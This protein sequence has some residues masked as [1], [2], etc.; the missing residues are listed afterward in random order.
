MAQAKPGGFIARLAFVFAMAALV[1]AALPR[2]LAAQ[3]PSPFVVSGVTVDET[4]ATAAQARE[5]AMA[6][7][8]RRAFRQLMERLVPQEQSAQLPRP[9]AAQLNDLVENF[10]VEDER[11]SAVR[12]IATLTFRFSPDGVRALL[13]RAGLPFAETFARPM[14]MLPVFR[15]DD[16]PVLWDEPNPW[17]AAWRALPPE[18]GLQPLAIPLGD[19]SDIGNVSAEQAVRGE[20]ERIEAI[21]RRYGAAGAIV[22]E[23]SLDD[24]GDAPVV[25]VAV[26]RLDSAVPEQTVVESFAGRPGETREALLE[27]AASQVSQTIQERW[28]SEV[29]L[30][31]GPERTLVSEVA[32]E[33]LTEWIAVRNRLA[34]SASVRKAEVLSL[35]RS[36]AR[37]ELHFVGS[38]S[39]LRLALA[40]RDLVLAPQGGTWTLTLRRSDQEP[41]PRAP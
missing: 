20:F 3:A 4:A 9:S 33:G 14:V 19:L 34:E 5:T 10:E 37:V 1:G 27:R 30:R 40:Q 15:A 17:L 32:F 18:D 24:A 21:A 22:A 28:K 13:R 2:P 38:E 25:Q 39:T 41:T 26:T 16:V 23:A 35:S 6:E 29:L 36:R 11:S 7:G 31:G 12:Y 8:Q